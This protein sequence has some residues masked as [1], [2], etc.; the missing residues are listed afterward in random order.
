M[1]YL[2]KLLLVTSLLV[3]C[4]EAPDSKITDGVMSEVTGNND[5]IN[6]RYSLLLKELSTKT[7]LTDDELIKAFPKKMRNRD[8]DDLKPVITGNQLVAGSFGN[9][10]VRMEILDAAGE[11][12]VGA[13]LPLKMLHLNNITSENNN[14][15][16]YTKKTRN[17]LLTFG[18]DRDKN[19]KADF[20]S[21]LRF[22][23][24]NRF[25]VTLQGKGMDTD[26]LWEAADISSL[27]TFKTLE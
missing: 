23:Y 11:K 10:S 27:K 7:T 6:E 16:R 14:T 12:A 15:I 17:G 1:K 21:E 9:N 19:T 4:K 5:N 2:L 13:V 22:L 18:I 8:L 25:Y 20:Q 26:A 3:S 24:D